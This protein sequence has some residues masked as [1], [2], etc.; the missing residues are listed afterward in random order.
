VATKSL[1]PVMPARPWEI[2]ITTSASRVA[3]VV[4][5]LFFYRLVFLVSLSVLFKY[6]KWRQQEVE[7]MQSILTQY[8]SSMSQS[9]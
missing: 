7:L 1:V 8:A 4:R 3:L 5:L 2:Y 9:D 6:F